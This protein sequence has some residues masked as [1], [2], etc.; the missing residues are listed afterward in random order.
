M[1]SPYFKSTERSSRRYRRYRRSS[2]NG[3]KQLEA[4]RA[5]ARRILL[6]IVLLSIA[7]VAGVVVA[8]YLVSIK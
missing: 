2:F 1:A 7:L 5:P 4:A 3:A 8:A 6:I